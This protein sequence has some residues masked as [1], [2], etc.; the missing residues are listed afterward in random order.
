MAVRDLTTVGVSVVRAAIDP[1][2]ASAIRRSIESHESFS[3]NRDEGQRYA[4]PFCEG[5]SSGCRAWDDALVELARHPAVLERVEKLLGSNC[6]IDSTAVSVQWPGEPMFGPH[7][8]R[9]FDKGASS[10][11]YSASASS[12]L[13]PLDFPVSIQALWVLDNI[14]TA[15]GA[16]YYVKPNLESSRND[17]VRSVAPEAQGIDLPK[18]AQMVTAA[19]GSVILAHGGVWHGAA[20]NFFARPRL[21]VL[22][23]YVP[24]YVRPGR[25]YPYS[26][27]KQAVEREVDPARSR[28]LVELFDVEAQ[29][30]RTEEIVVTHDAKQ[31]RVAW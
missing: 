9:P 26:M 10:W 23:Q 13:P 2:A 6:I 3:A 31:K 4:H 19:A 18:G 17:S 11:K 14:T 16:F 1:S 25:R 24:A 22:V 21:S 5:Q 28:R 8:D 7:V 20:P 15:N 12:G 29:W 30:K 27:I